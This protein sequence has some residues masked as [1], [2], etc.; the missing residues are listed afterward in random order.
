MRILD[1]LMTK[2]LLILYF[3][4]FNFIL[5]AISQPPPPPPKDDNP[6]AGSI[7]GNLSLLLLFGIIYGINKYKS[8]KKE[9]AKLI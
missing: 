5:E 7:E 9:I 3:L 4:V 2:R 6:W 8:L 1:K